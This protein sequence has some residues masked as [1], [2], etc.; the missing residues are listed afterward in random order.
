MRISI[1]TFENDAILKQD[2]LR[3]DIN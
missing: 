1:A 3:V 2:S